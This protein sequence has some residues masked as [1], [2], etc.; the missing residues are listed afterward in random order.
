MRKTG[1][2]IAYIKIILSCVK[3]VTIRLIND[4]KFFET[5]RNIIIAATRVGK[6]Y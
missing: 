3:K 5:E 4:M 2:T 1:M 6:E